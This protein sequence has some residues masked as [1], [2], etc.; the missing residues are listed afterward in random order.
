MVIEQLNKYSHDKYI[1]D[2]TGQIILVLSLM[3]TN[4][5]SHSAVLVHLNYM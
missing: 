2:L 4:L 1:Y 5:G 3:T